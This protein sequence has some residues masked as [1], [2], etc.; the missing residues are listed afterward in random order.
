MV[1][2]LTL[3]ILYGS[4]NKQQLFYYTTLTYRFLEPR[5]RVFT[6]RYGLNLYITHMIRLYRVQVHLQTKEYDNVDW[7]HLAQVKV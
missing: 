2:T 3:S 6:A 1:S 5:W 4:Q 7:F